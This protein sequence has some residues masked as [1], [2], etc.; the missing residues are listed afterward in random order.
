MRGV[1]SSHGQCLNEAGEEQTRS[2]SS[3]LLNNVTL[4]CATK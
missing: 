1:G 4:V 2:H 3:L